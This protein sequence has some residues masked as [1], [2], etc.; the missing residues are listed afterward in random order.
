MKSLSVKTLLLIT[1]LTL[2]N[3][4]QGQMPPRKLKTCGSMTAN[5]NVVVRVDYGTLTYDSS[6]SMNAEE[7][8][9]PNLLGKTQYKISHE[10]KTDYDSRNDAN[11]Q[12]IRLKQV[13]VDVNID[14]IK[15]LID[16][17]LVPGTC[18]YAKVKD[19]ENEHVRILR[20]T[21]KEEAQ[22]MKI[23]LMGQLATI[24]PIGALKDR[25]ETYNQAMTEIE[26]QVEV[27]VRDAVKGIARKVD[28]EQDEID[29]NK[30][31][32]NTFNDCPKE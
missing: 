14:Y 3:A 15:V 8:A 25:P 29:T 20:N 23:S 7:D 13:E 27:I 28:D 6:K 32:R 11:M 10:F 21:V 18:R 24:Q 12:C 30:S 2:S 16:K 4:A 22:K 5:I 1:A 26:D 17:D 19:H 9:P 31:Y